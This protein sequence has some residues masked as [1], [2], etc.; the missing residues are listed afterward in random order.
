MCNWRT[1]NRLPTDLQY[2]PEHSSVARYFDPTT[3]TATAGTPACD[4]VRAAIDTL[5]LLYVD[6]IS[7]NAADTY[8]DAAYLIARNRHLIADQA[9]RDTLVQFPEAN[10]SDVDERKC[11]RDINIV[12]SGLIRDLVLGGN[13]GIVTAAE[14]YFTGTQL[15]GIETKMLAQTIYAYQK[16]RDYSIDALSN[17]SAGTT[18]P[19]VVTPST[20]TYTANT[21]DLTVTF[22]TP[23]TAVTTSHRF[24]FTEEALTFTCDIDSGASTHAYPRRVPADVKAYGRSLE[25]TNVSTSG[26][27]TTVTVNVG[28]ASGAAASSTH[29][30][31]SAS[32]GAVNVQSG[33]EAGNQKTPS[34]ASYDPITGDMTLAFASPHGM[35]TSDTI[36]LDDPTTFVKLYYNGKGTRTMYDRRVEA[37]VNQEP[38]L[39]PAKFDDGLEIEI[40]VNV[41]FGD[42]LKAMG[43]AEKY[44]IVIGRL[45]TEL[46]KDVETV[47]IHKGL[48][49]FGGGNNNLLIHT[50]WSLKHYEEQGILEETLVHEASH[51]SLDSYHSKDPDWLSAQ[52]KAV[53][54]TH[55][56]L[57]T[58][59]IV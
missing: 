54:Y 33:A 51:T 55:L 41:E 43:E 10:L 14:E 6:V 1:G 38:F 5:S 57:P 21:G 16:V 32:T 24:A 48:K 46:R 35:S 56:T 36:T 7:N 22:P 34:S 2:V 19:A 53:S 39:F 58:K 3:R 27:N 30:F 12:L 42:Y 9:L 49:P 45:T 47:W 37:W 17:W 11:R 20:A 18:L 44:A 50:D 28:P 26:G 31:D 25:I 52:L 15:T 29:T 23:T 4:D 40:Q 13:T 59:R 8:L